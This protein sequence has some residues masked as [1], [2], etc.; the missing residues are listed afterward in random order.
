MEVACSHFWRCAESLV[1]LGLDR[2]MCKGLGLVHHELQH[3]GFDAESEQ[4]KSYFV[5]LPSQSV[6][7]PSQSQKTQ[8][9]LLACAN[10]HEPRCPSVGGLVHVAGGISPASA[11]AKVFGSFA[12]N[13]GASTL[14]HPAGNVSP[15]YLYPTGPCPTHSW[16]RELEERK[17]RANAEHILKIEHPVCAL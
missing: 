8:S 6:Q 10:V 5:Q 4:E 17:W 16:H 13:H 12:S 2:S 11:R 7:L 3:Q 9:T 1:D 14:L 15:A